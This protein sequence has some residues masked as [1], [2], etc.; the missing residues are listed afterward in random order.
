[1]RPRE[2]AFLLS[3]SYLPTSTNLASGV[4]ALTCNG[5]PQASNAGQGLTDGAI[6]ND[7]SETFPSLIEP[8][9]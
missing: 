5:V 7:D 6:R 1:M 2:D 8:M 3:F 9:P 4:R